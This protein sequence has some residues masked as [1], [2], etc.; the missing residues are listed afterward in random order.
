VRA[1]LALVFL[2]A[3][4][5]CGGSA[6]QAQQEAPQHTTT[7]PCRHSGPLTPRQQRY[8]RR[9]NADLAAMRA[10]KTHAQASRATDRFLLDVGVGNLPIFRANRL[11][12]HAIAAVTPICQDCFQALEAA[13]PIARPSR[14]S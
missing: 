13:R 10:A 6:R 3:L 1:A 11:I 12:D 4:T 14:C 8:F 5:A 7:A 9:A 2:L